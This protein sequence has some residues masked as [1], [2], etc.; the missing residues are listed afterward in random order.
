MASV[1]DVEKT[2]ITSENL[3]DLGF[4]LW[5]GYK[6]VYLLSHRRWGSYTCKY[7]DR[8]AK[9]GNKHLRY[10]RV[11]VRTFSIKP[12]KPKVTVYRNVDHSTLQ[13]IVDNIK[14]NEFQR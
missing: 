7:W 6:D 9:F 5:L 3:N 2:K 13:A 1:F 4:Q 11:E 12:K 8:G 14:R 10:N